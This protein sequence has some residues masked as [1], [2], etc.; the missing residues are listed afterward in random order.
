MS[1]G[2]FILFLLKFLL[3]HLFFPIAFNWSRLGSLIAL[4]TAGVNQQYL[5]ILCSGDQVYNLFLML[6]TWSFS[7]TLSEKGNIFST[8]QQIKICFLFPNV[9][10]H[11][12]VHVVDRIWAGAEENKL[13]IWQDESNP[14]ISQTFSWNWGASFTKPK[15]TPHMTAQYTRKMSCW[16]FR[17]FYIMTITMNGKK[18]NQPWAA[19]PTDDVSTELATRTRNL[20]QDELSKNC[21]L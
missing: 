4:V 12:P 14:T 18:L 3:F 9:T 2:T 17:C 7:F 1:P 13:I 8:I 21:D 15:N 5:K 19:A 16:S 11:I 20:F 6:E 10:D